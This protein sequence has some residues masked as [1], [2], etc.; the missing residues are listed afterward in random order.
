M[1]QA[2]DSLRVSGSHRPQPEVIGI[3]CGVASDHC[4]GRYPGKPWKLESLRTRASHRSHN[5]SNRSNGYVL[6][7]LFWWLSQYP[8]YLSC[9]PHQVG[10]LPQPIIIRLRD[11]GILVVGLT[12]TEFMKVR[13]ECTEC[14]RDTP[15]VPG[16]T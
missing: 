6:S 9:G 8:G 4:V 2:R 16:R 15:P 5:Y 13:P 1:I 7:D 12:H 10:C 11:V 3:R 14:V